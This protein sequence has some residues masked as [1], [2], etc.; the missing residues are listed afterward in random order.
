MTNRERIRVLR[1]I[2]DK[3]AGVSEEDLGFERHFTNREM[4]A[5]NWA[6]KACDKYE[7]KREAEK[8]GFYDR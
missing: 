3:N 8:R 1:E 5:L 2:R 4:E 6:I 7:S